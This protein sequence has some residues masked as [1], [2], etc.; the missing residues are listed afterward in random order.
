MEMNR[1]RYF[2]IGVLL[3]LL[4][5]QFRMIDSF[6]LNEPTTRALANMS[7][8]A[9]PTPSDSF[10]TFLMQVHPKPTKRV[11]PPRWLG[12]AMIAV[13]SVVSLHALAIPRNG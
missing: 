13:G 6:V 9:T 3:V 8:N 4:G 1:N 7:R 10:S 11:H 2:L 12:L 5:S